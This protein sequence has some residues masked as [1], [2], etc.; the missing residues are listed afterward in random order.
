MC[1]DATLN[2]CTQSWLLQSFGVSGVYQSILK[3][4]ELVFFYRHVVA[5]VAIMFVQLLPRPASSPS[6]MLPVAHAVNLQRA[7]AKRLNTQKVA[8]LG[9]V[10]HGND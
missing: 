8:G 9:M 7:Q 1:S 3:R 4:L 10:G 6:S 5:L 2:I